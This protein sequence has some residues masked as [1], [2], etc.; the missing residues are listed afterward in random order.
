MKN[1]F[2]LFLLLV[3]CKQNNIIPPV[4][5]PP[6]VVDNRVF[7]TPEKFVMGG[8]LSFV[9]QIEDSGG[10]YRDSQKIKDSYR[11]L[12]DRGMNCV[13]V[14]LW[15]TPTWTAKTNDKGN[16]YSDLKDVSRSIRRAK[17]LGMAVNLCIH[18][19]DTWADP[20]GQKTP[21]AW[22]K[23]DYATLKDS[24][25]NYTF[26]VLKYLE[27]QNLTPEMIQ[28]GNEVTPGMLFPKGQ[29]VN[30]NWQPFCDL[31]KS[32]IK[33]VRDFSKTSSLKPQI[34]LHVAQFQH[35]DWWA[36]G[37]INKGGVTDFDI[38]GISHYYKWSTV[39]SMATIGER[40]KALK[41]KYNKKVMIV[42]TAFSWTNKGGDNYNNFM[43]SD[44]PVDS[45]MISEAGQQLYLKDL[46]QQLI[47]NGGSGI[48]Y[49]EPAWITSPMRDL[50][51]T[52]S[53]WE[54]NALFDFQGNALPG[55]SFMTEKY[56]F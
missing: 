2:F 54:N 13:R 31:L 47:S 23:L 49:W 1:L 37:V 53:S 30:N 36:D 8:D 39:N 3:A 52:G 4:V 48:M 20:Q 38:L 33:A 35:A 9:N 15:H 7:Y 6:V 11:L 55:M 27:K 22:E 18:Y 28:I 5:T 32:G 26:A 16:L 43:S 25:Y 10:V 17:A 19:S 45:Y 50:W 56:A 44:T 24:M 41:T 51:G 21:A 29:V 42:E 14:R 12:K 46:T 40:V 34:I